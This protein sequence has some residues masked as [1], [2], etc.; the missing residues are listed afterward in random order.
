MARWLIV[1]AVGDQTKHN[2]VE[3]IPTVSK[4]TPTSSALKSTVDSVSAE[5]S[6]DTN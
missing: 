1:R 6:L 5:S 3:V 4:P 2:K